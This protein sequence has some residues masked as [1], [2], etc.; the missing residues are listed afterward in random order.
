MMRLF[1][2][3]HL[4]GEGGVGGVDVFAK[5]GDGVVSSWMRDSS[6]ELKDVISSLRARAE[7]SA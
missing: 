1:Q 4:C 5:I 7:E 3:E 6:I 2:G